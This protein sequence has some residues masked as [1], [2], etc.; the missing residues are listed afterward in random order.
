MFMV[1]GT[2]SKRYM[3]NTMRSDMV[4]FELKEIKGNQ[5]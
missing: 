3:H 4:T 1:I 2:W 5:N